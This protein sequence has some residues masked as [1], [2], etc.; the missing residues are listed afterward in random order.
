MRN[1][2]TDPELLKRFLDWRGIE[3]ACPI[4]GGSG[5][6]VYSQT[7]TW[8]GGM[9]GNVM[10]SDVCDFCWGSGDKYRHGANIRELER[11]ERQRITAEAALLLAR[12][13]GVGF[14]DSKAIYEE[15]AKEMG[16]LARGRKER[17]RWFAVVCETLARTFREMAEAAE[18]PP[19]R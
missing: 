4:C 16:R 7:C 3:E 18:K 1:R 14:S 6:R 12:R 13:A 15:L 9:G 19:L 17:P 8:R 2:I 5:R 11:T 10:T